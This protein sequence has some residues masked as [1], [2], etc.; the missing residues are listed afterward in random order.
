MA[1]TPDYDSNNSDVT[2]LQEPYTDVT[3]LKEPYRINDFT[4]ENGV[5]FLYI[6]PRYTDPILSTHS[7]SIDSYSQNI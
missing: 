3:P 2:P 4:V 5:T 1:D 6:T 7:S